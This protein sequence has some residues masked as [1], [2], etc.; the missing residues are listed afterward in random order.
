[1]FIPI[2]PLVEYVVNYQYISE[3]LC[4]NKDKPQMSC[5]GK[6]YLKKQVKASI[7]KTSPSDSEHSPNNYSYDFRIAVVHKIGTK[8]IGLPFFLLPFISQNKVLTSRV[9]DVE[10]KPPIS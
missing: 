6:C 4:E 10:D 7:E 5:S 8:Y 2:V 9:L 1:M 3:V